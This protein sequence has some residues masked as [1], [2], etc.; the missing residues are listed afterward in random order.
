N[1][2]CEDGF[3]WAN[4]AAGVSPCVMAAATFACN[5]AGHNVPPLT[6]GAHYDPP[7]LANNTVNVC[8]CSWA[9]YN[10]ISMCTL[11][12]GEIFSL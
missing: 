12:Q 8:Q 2:T 4:N 5:T 1:A 7:N 6:P 10:L 11:C 3:D 9:A